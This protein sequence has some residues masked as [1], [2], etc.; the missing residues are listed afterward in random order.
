MSVTFLFEHF[1][2]KYCLLG[3][4]T[5]DKHCQLDRCQLFT[6]I[7]RQKIVTLAVCSIMSHILEGEESC[8]D[9]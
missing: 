7:I 4:E 2:P 1:L 8:Y 5:I 6:P 9:S 3:P